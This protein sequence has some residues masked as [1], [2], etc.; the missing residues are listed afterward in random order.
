MPPQWK[1]EELHDEFS[2]FGAIV[3]SKVRQDGARKFGWVQFEDQK[4]AEAAIDSMNGRDVVDENK[5]TF[6]LAVSYHSSHK[7]CTVFASH[8]Q[9]AYLTQEKLIAAFSVF[10]PI[11]SVSLKADKIPPHAF[12]NF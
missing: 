12:I 7:D 1:S 9:S 11:V 4:A 10:G 3:S 8:L 5:E 6:K 2:T